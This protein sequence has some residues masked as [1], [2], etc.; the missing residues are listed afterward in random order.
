MSFRH[1]LAQERGA[2]IED[3]LTP[4]LVV[5]AERPFERLFDRMIHGSGAV[6]M[7]A[8]FLPQGVQHS[9]R[10]VRPELLDNEAALGIGTRMKDR[11]QAAPDAVC[12]TLLRF[13]RCDT[14]TK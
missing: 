7:P 13:K 14:L 11:G 1:R 3:R 9:Q 5:G 10:A 2:T 8:I 12:G 6:V 4:P